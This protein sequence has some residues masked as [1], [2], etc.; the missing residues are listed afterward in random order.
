MNWPAPLPRHLAAATLV[1]AVSVVPGSAPVAPHGVADVPVVTLTVHHSQ[2][3]RTRL[4]VPA[5]LVRFVVRNTDPIDHELII[6]DQSVQDRHERGTE[7]R[8]PPR[9]GEVTVPAGGTSG[10]VYVFAPS[11]SVLFGCH[12][13]GHWAYGMHGEMSVSYG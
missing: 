6:G 7:P 10:T 8:H 13:P 12:L 1:A 5:G 3:S 11:G 4:R 2:F 9:P